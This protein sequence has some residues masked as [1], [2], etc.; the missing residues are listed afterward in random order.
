MKK[1]NS[2]YYKIVYNNGQ[3]ITADTAERALRWAASIQ[4]EQRDPVYIREV[5]EIETETTIGE[6]KKGAGRIYINNNYYI[7]Y[8]MK[9]GG[10]VFI[11][12][13]GATLKQ[14]KAAGEKIKK[15]GWQIIRVEKHTESRETIEGAAIIES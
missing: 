4:K 14:L 1:Y 10:S 6:F 5:D 11:E 7:F 8:K 12:D 15:K 13:G 3:T 9:T 2:H